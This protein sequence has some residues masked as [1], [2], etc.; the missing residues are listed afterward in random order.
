MW[1]L[2]IFVYVGVRIALVFY[3]FILFFVKSRY[4]NVGFQSVIEFY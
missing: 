4:E 3:V 2:K 1:H